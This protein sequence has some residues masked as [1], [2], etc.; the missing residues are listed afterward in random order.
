MRKT[1]NYSIILAVVF[2]LSCQGRSD[3]VKGKNP[4]NDSISSSHLGAWEM[5][6]FQSIRGT[7]TTKLISSGAP[8]AITL[9]T[10]S[11]F[12]YQWRNSSISGAGTYT[13]DGSIIHEEFKYFQDSSFVGAILSFNMDVRN[14]SLIFS[15]PIK[16]VSS[17]GKDLLNQIPQM[18]EI[19]KRSD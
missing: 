19:R 14:D 8:L 2:I 10:P 12:S 15:G 13:Y 3:R 7:D 4:N 11:H 17:T 5:I 6:Y 16:A 9:M 1:I 18:L